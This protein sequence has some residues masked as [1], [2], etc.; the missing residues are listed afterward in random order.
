MSSYT[1]PKTIIVKASARRPMTP[2]RLRQIKLHFI[3]Y[4]DYASYRNS[5]HWLITVEKF[6]NSEYVPVENN[7]LVCGLC[8]KPNESLD[9]YHKNDNHF[10]CEEMTDLTLLCKHCY[11]LKQRQWFNI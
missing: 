7:Q 4:Q 3:G 5:K 9:V 10:G 2:G 1:E 8:Q 11:Y 6:L